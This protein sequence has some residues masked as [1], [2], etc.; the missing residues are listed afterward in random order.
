MTIVWDTVPAHI[1]NDIDEFN[2]DNNRDPTDD[3]IEAFD[4]WLTWN[5]IVG[6]S[7]SIRQALFEL[8]TSD[9]DYLIAQDLEQENKLRKLMGVE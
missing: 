5:G 2:R 9:G 1:K 8:I 7:S 3:P 4:R 6:Y